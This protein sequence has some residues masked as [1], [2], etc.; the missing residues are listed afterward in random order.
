MKIDIRCDCKVKML[1]SSMQQWTYFCVNREC[2]KENTTIK[3]E[4]KEE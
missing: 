3:L 1:Q 2:P 4:V